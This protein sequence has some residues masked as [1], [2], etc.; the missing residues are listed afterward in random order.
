MEDDIANG[1]VHIIHDWQGLPSAE[2]SGC[3]WTTVL[4]DAKV[5]HRKFYASKHTAIQFSLR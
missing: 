3:L 5:R 2:L 4:R 1:F